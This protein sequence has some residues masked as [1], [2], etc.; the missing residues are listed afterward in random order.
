MFWFFLYRTLSIIVFVIGLPI[1]TVTCLLVKKWKEGLDQKLGLIDWESIKKLRGSRF[2]ELLT[3]LKDSEAKGSSVEL[4]E[5][6]STNI[7]QKNIWLH[8]VSFG[9]VK[10]IE[11]LVYRLQEAFPDYFI[12]LSTGTKTGQDLARRLFTDLTTNPRLKK[13][14]F[15]FYK[16]F[17]FYFA[18][19]NWLDLIQPSMLIV[20]ETE[21]WPELLI[22]SQSRKIPCFLVNARLTKKSASGYKKVLPLWKAVLRAFNGIYVQTELEQ[23]LFESIGASAEQISVIGNLKFDSMQPASTN[24]LNELK[25][26]LKLSEGSCVFVAGSTHREEED[27]VC[28]AFLAALAKYK[29]QD[30]RLILAPRHPERLAEVY[31]ICKKT[32]LTFAKRS[33]FK[34]F[35][36]TLTDWK[37]LVL[38]TLGE[39]NK[40]YGLGD[41]A[42]LGGTWADVGGHNPLEAASYG[43]TSLLGPN[44]YKIQDLVK[45]LKR[46][47]LVIEFSSEEAFVQEFM[48][49]L[50]ALVGQS[51]EEKEDAKKQKIAT[52]I[53]QKNLSGTTIEMIKAQLRNAGVNQ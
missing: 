10:T 33:S 30:L 39:L 40:F 31:E 51:K 12:C 6:E 46:A 24:I 43:I 19:K 9:E 44:S 35:E 50:E 14:V 15:V 17:D 41:F 18:V 26:E 28:K 47:A 11:P 13:E 52:F 1:V 38:D 3:Q 53:P 29:D 22:Q 27:L 4:K 7:K 48:A 2:T 45:Q 5:F 25:T 20:A 36:E 16:P 21:I 49:T 8:A 32:Q 42:F 23:T 37:I 34:N